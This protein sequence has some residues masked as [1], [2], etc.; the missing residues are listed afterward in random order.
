MS[1]LIQQLDQDGQNDDI[2]K[3]KLAELK[4]QAKARIKK[5][6]QD[7]A[8]KKI[9][10]LQ[11][12]AILKATKGGAGATLVGLIITY[13]I[14]TIQFI[15]GNIFESKNIPKLGLGETIIW[16]CATFL[17]IV[18]TIAA[19]TFSIIMIMGTISIACPAC[20]LTM[21]GAEIISYLGF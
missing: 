9:K 2:N 3:R 14:M 11:K 20:A 21:F 10:E 13:A 1:E 15:A 7:K 18:G 5:K 12:K 17:I 4:Q 6:V 16:V 8:K 19:L